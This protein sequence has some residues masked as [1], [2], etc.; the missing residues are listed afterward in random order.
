M[1]LLKNIPLKSK[2]QK[3]IVTDV[4][5]Q[6]TKAPKPLVI[7]VHGYKGYKDWGAFDKMSTLFLN[8]GVALLKFNFSHNGGTLEHPIDFPD[9]DAFG[10][11]NYTME[12]DDLQTVIDWISEN[13]EHHTEIRHQQ[14]HV[15]RSFSRRW[16]I[17]TITAANDSR[18]KKLVTWASVCTL[19]RSMF[20]EGPELEQ[21]K[22][23]G[24][25]L[26][27]ER[28]YQTANAALYSVL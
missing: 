18:I 25:F 6:E 9:L 28:S 24:R 22:K 8:E 4:Y 11:N 7:F 19:D 21:W 14:H 23:R 26:R 3:P 15:N 27:D 16:K 20:Q 5:Y 2:H 1:I 17:S 13:T 12:L 10:K